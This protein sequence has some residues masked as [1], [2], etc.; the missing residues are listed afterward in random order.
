M[1]RK[2]GAE[3]LERDPGLAGR[4]KDVE[5]VAC[6]TFGE[7]L[8]ATMVD[9]GVPVALKHVYTRNAKG[10]R[11][12]AFVMREVHALQELQHPNVVQMLQCVQMHDAVLMVL[13]W[14]PHDLAGLLTSKWAEKFSRAQV[15]TY[16]AEIL[17]ALAYCH[18]RNMMHRDV[19]PENLLVGADGHLRLADFGLAA[20]HDPARYGHYT[21]K[22]VTMWYRAPE[23]LMGARAYGFPVDAWSAG[24]VLGEMM[25]RCPLL[26]GDTEPKQMALTW[27][28]CGTADAE[29]MRALPHWEQ[30]RPPHGVPPSASVSAALDSSVNKARSKGMSFITPGVLEVVSGLMRVDPA[31]RMTCADALACHYFV[32]EY[33]SIANPPSYAREAAMRGRKPTSSPRSSKKQAK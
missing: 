14:M 33:P 27:A 24:C 29:S 4:F 20:A 10:K 32:G 18:S 26:M 6:G 23:L 12:D 11:V 28:L 15:K 7:V 13:E 30:M 3:W 22:V 1:S 17:S 31:R 8:R 9:G 21:N 5:A 16:A 2:R 25:Q 19:K